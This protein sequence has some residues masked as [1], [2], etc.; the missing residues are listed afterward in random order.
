MRW[1]RVEGG[2][3]GGVGGWMDWG[4]FGWS[5][6]ERV[7]VRIRVGGGHKYGKAAL[8]HGNFF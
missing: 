1:R 6:M 4:R 3:E 2:G 8:V 7:G 5:G